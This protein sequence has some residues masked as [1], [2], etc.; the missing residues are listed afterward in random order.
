MYLT[1]S[2]IELIGKTPL[3]KINNLDT[4]GNDIYIKLE[5][6]N[7]GRST[8]DRIA[9]KIIQES[10]K[11]NLIDKDT[12]IIEATSGNTGIGLAIVCAVKGYKLKL[13]CLTPARCWKNTAYESLWNWS[14]TNWR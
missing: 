9:L 10:W 13:T 7:P 12:I 1:N 6:N 14:Y 4:F 8:K 3:V 2:V 5:G 11:E